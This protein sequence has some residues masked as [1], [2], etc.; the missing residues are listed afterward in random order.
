MNGLACAI[1]AVAAAGA[2]APAL[3]LP[4]TDLLMALDARYGTSEVEE[5]PG[6]W[7]LAAWAGQHGTSVHAAQ[8]TGGKRPMLTTSAALGGAAVVVSDG[9]DDIMAL[10]GLS[11]ASGPVTAYFVAEH[12]APSGV[13]FARWFDSQTGRLAFGIV[14]DDYAITRVVDNR[15]TSVVPGTYAGRVT[16]QQSGTAGRLWLGDTEATP[17]A[18]PSNAALG[19]ASRIFANFADSS[20]WAAVGIALALIYAAQH[21]STQRASVWDWIAQELPA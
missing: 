8:G 16:F 10:S 12:A 2:S 19:G 20:G 17:V 18:T 4:T 1:R 11:I 6:V 13:A 3:P 21:D 14:S 7:R 9:I 5:S 15:F